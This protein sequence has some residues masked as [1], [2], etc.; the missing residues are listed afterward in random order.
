M[1]A[2]ENSGSL[3]GNIYNVGL[4]DANVSKRELCD[5]IAQEVQGFYHHEAAVGQD[6]DQRNYVVS[7]A[8]IEATGFL[9]EVSLKDGIRE[10]VKGLKMLN[11]KKFGNA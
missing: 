7:N 3:A 6:P 10:L 11:N 9:P 4:S 8:K 5:A 1:H 2:I